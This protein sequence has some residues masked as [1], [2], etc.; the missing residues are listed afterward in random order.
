VIGWL[1]WV[2]TALVFL[3]VVLDDRRSLRVVNLVAAAAMLAVAL[4]VGPVS[5]VAVDTAV[6]ALA[7]HHLVAGHLPSPRLRLTSA[8]SPNR[9]GVTRMA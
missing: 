2:G 3:S 1:A 9:R 6:V 4:T 5:L 7:V 8:E